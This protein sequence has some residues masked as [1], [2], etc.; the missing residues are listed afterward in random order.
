MKTQDTVTVF[1]GYVKLHDVMG[2]DLT[3]VNSARVSYNKKK[4]VLDEKDRRLIQFLATNGHTSPFRHATLQFEVYAPL[5]VARQWWKYVVGADHVMD[6]WNESSRRY[7][8]EECEFYIPSYEQWRSAPDNKKQGSGDPVTNELG[9]ELT[10]ALLTHINESVALYEWA[11]NMG[12][13][14][15]Q[16]RLF[17]P[18]YG[19]YVRWYW[20]ASLQ[21]VAHLL[22]QRL[23]HDAQWEFQEYAKAIYKLTEPHFP[24]SLEVLVHGD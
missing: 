23:N 9:Y 17:L 12:V 15:E 16:A 20:T 7:I 21:S 8:T 5:M 4:E 14:A 22:K 11:Q 6:G 1:D 19:M 10:G 24:F 3:I 2:S 13:C 18:A